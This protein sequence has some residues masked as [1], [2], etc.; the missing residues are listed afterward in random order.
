MESRIGE[1]GQ[2]TNTILIYAIIILVWM[3]MNGVVCLVHRLC[4]AAKQ[5]IKHRFFGSKI[6]YNSSICIRRCACMPFTCTMAICTR[7]G[8]CSI[9]KP[10][11][12]TIQ[13]SCKL[14]FFFACSFCSLVFAASFV[15]CADRMHVSVNVR[16]ANTQRIV[17]K[18]N[19]YCA[20]FENTQSVAEYLTAVHIQTVN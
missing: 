10:V 3:E 20:D 14:F 6:T 17:C 12:S 5:Q 8:V 11:P 2:I 15:Q 1:R 7:H 19:S 9:C 16:F 13:F 18:K 4:V